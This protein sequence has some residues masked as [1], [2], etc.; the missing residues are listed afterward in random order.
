M[1]AR[2][3][4][5]YGEHVAAL[6]RNGLAG[7]GIVV[8]SGGA[9]GIDAAAHRSALGGE[10]A[11]VIVSAGGVDRPYPAANAALY[12][13]ATERGLVISESPPGSAPQRHRFLSRNRLI[14][15]LSTGTVVVEAAKRSGAL[16]TASH[17]VTLGRPLMVVP[18][19]ITS[20][21]SVG[22]H[23]LLRREDYGALLVSSVAEVAGI[24]GGVSWAAADDESAQPMCLRVRPT[25]G[26]RHSTGWIRSPSGCST[27]CQCGAGD[28]K[29]TWPLGPVSPS[30]TCC[31]LCRHYARPA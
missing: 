23:D 6:F 17:A 8:V 24:V 15:A 27:G 16:N 26:G 12:E 11:T 10:G 13:R 9:L 28:P 18:G 7:R 1:G 4:S 30:P 29:T 22:C 25:C 2:S 31:G 5:A 14:A 3:A 19:P 20:A 21:M